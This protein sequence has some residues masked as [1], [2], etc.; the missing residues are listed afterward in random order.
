M[1]LYGPVQSYDTLIILLAFSLFFFT[2]FFLYGLLQFTGHINDKNFVGLSTSSDYIACGSENNAAYAY[3]KGLSKPVLCYRFNSRA[4]VRFTA[5]FFVYNLYGCLVQLYWP[6]VVHM[7]I[8]LSASVWKQ[9]QGADGAVE[10]G[11]HFVSAVCWK[12]DE[13]VLLAANSQGAINVMHLEP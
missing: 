12:K 7:Y 13:D 3:Y 11:N 2:L 6:A 8:Y 1:Q 4:D 5:S 9:V 10:D